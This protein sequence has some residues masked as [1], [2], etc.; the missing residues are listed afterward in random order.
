MESSYNQIENEH[1]SSL[2]ETLAAI[3]LYWEYVLPFLQDTFSIVNEYES[4]GEDIQ[5]EVTVR[6]KFEPIYDIKCLK[7][8]IVVPGEPPL[9]YPQSLKEFNI[10]PELLS[11]GKMILNATNIESGVVN[12]EEIFISDLN[13][14]DQEAYELLQE[15]KINML[16]LLVQEGMSFEADDPYIQKVMDLAYKVLGPEA[17]DLWK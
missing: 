9:T 10:T 3:D 2:Q 8:I 5:K 12:S 1:V 14:K 7:S 4:N 15:L 11:Q 13:I 6:R 16:A 17:E